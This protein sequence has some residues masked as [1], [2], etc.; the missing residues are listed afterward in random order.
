MTSSQSTPSVPSMVSQP[1]RRNPPRNQGES[2]CFIQYRL[3]YI[4]NL[5]FPG[6]S[7]PSS[8]SSGSPSP[9]SFTCPTLI[10]TAGEGGILTFNLTRAYNLHGEPILM[11]QVSSSLY[12]SDFQQLTGNCD[13]GKPLIYSLVCMYV[14]S[15]Q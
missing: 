5:L 9:G 12:Q 14:Y 6:P 1:L 13:S 7:T 4:L 3:V 2:F 11:E 10:N 8:S 15:N